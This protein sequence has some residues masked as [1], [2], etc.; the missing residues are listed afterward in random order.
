MLVRI[1][2]ARRPLVH[3][4]KVTDVRTVQAVATLLTPISIACVL[5][6][7]WKVG[8]DMDW[9]EPFAIDKGIFSHF[10]VWFALG[11]GV[12]AASWRLARYGH[13]L[14]RDAEDYAPTADTTLA[15]AD[16]LEKKRAAI[17]N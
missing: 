12:Q 6:G 11:A 4:G 16:E 8:A 3:K 1:P 14:D 2:F 9:A 15:E 5:M 7:A 17:A 13:E 10:Q